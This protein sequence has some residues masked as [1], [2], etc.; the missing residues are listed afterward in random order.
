VDDTRDV[1]QNREQDV[2]EQV[3]AA[4]TLEEDSQRREEDGKNDLED[5]AV[6]RRIMVSTL[7][8][9]DCVGGER[10]AALPSGERHDCGW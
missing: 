4:A 8:S 3:G 7:D 5:V 2:D 10:N 9:A 6:G 1:T